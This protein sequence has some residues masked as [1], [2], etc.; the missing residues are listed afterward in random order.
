[1][2]YI[3]GF[4]SLVNMFLASLTNISNSCNHDWDIVYSIM[5]SSPYELICKLFNHDLDFKV[6]IAT[7]TQVI[8]KRKIC[9]PI[10]NAALKLF[11]KA[12][13]LTYLEIFNIIVVD[14]EH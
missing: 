9:Q 3:I 12:M 11:I 6:Y 8:A 2:A 7:N 1:M 5:R 10:F 4:K 13:D 14:K